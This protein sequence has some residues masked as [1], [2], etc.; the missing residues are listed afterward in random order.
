M[1]RNRFLLAAVIGVLLLSCVNVWGQVTA[2]ATVQ[3]TVYDKTHAVI[4]N[5]DVTITNKDT[6]VTRTTKTN[7]FGE[8]RFDVPAAGS[9]SLKAKVTGFSG[10]EAKDV[11]VLVGRT[12]TQDFALTPGAVTE[13]IEVTTTAP[14][15]DV[16]KTD[17][18]TNI[19]PQQIT[20]LPLI[21]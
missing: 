17:V 4:K 9:Y 21:G 20:D 8:Y 3:G 16:A 11:E 12:T 5:A 15:V 19:T 18:S 13:T 10:A 2:S 14:L 6:G 1:N 7:D